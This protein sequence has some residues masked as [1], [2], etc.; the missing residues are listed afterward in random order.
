MRIVS[1]SAPSFPQAFG[2]S[3]EFAAG[4]PTKTFGDDGGGAF[5]DGVVGREGTFEDGVVDRCGAF[6]NDRG[7]AF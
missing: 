3:P 2:G 1:A 5:E 6:E 7:G 4:S